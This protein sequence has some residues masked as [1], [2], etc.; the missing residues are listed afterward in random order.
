MGGERIYEFF[1]RHV[2]NIELMVVSLAPEGIAEGE[3]H[4]LYAVVLQTFFV[5]GIGFIVAESVAVK[6]F[7]SVPCGDPYIAVL[8]LNHIL[9]HFERKTCGA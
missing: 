2:E 4:I 7:Q 8:V 3:K 6:F 1:G 9:D 5:G